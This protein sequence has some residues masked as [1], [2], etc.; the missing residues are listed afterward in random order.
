M[1]KIIFL[2]A[3]SLVFVFSLSVLAYDHTITREPLTDDEMQKVIELGSEWFKNAQEKDGHFKYEYM[4]YWDRYTDD[5]NVV[6]QAG[7]LYELGEILVRDGN[8]SLGLKDTVESAIEYAVENS[9]SGEFGG[10]SFKCLA[11]DEK[12]CTLGGSS[13][14]FIGV[15]D[16]VTAYPDE[17][18]EYR[19]LIDGYKEY[20]LAM[21]LEDAGV[22]DAYYF[23][24]SQ[25]VKESSF[26]NGEVFLALV[27][28]YVYSGDEEVKMV[29]DGLFDY[30]NE[31]YR[32][33]WDNNFYL[34]GMAA[35]KDL[36][37][38]DPSDEYFDF[39]KDYTD[40]RMQKYMIKRSSGHNYCA[41][42]EGVISAYSVL[43]DSHGSEDYLEEIDF[44]LAK[45]RDLQ[46]TATTTL[47]YKY[48]DTKPY[49][50]R[51][52]D[53]N[54]AVGGF[55]TDQ[56]EPTQRIDFTQH[57]LSGY[58]QKLVDVNGVEL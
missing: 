41:Y 10:R 48:S 3:L 13:L 25:T 11:R 23:D 34:W 49:I 53:L 57:C 28:Y 43:E 40:W 44:W 15:L 52:K 29:I 26:S 14:A 27:R 45:S 16:Y 50:L 5:D 51:V 30:F 55:L 42:S 38:S 18:L 4:P 12:K 24:G 2:A 32:A 37:A 56:K 46:V 19:G 35:I 6:R 9:R 47:K 33:E 39:V 17:E 7:A 31:I 8:D 1:K 58:L 22:R 36:Y 21:N 20:F 54:R